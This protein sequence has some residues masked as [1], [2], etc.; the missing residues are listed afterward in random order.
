MTSVRL[1]V[2]GILLATTHAAPLRAQM[3]LAE[4]EKISAQT[5]R[6]MFVVAGKKT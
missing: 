5:G 3:S 1:L 6:T 4:A 2:A